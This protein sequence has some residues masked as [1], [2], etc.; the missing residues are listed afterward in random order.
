MGWMQMTFT[1]DAKKECA[2][3]DFGNQCCVLSELAAFVRI[4]GVLE[5][6]GAGKLGI[7]MSTENPATARRMYKLIKSAIRLEIK[8]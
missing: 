7:S 1:A 6:G 2:R 3:L 5:L 8:K 4:N